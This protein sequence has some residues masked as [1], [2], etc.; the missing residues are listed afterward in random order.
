M[1]AD[2]GFERAR[3]NFGK[4]IHQFQTET[5]TL[6][7]KLERILIKLYRQNVSLLFNQTYIYI[8][9]YIYIYK[10]YK[11]PNLPMS[12]FPPDKA[13][14]NKYLPNMWCMIFIKTN[15]SAVFTVVVYTA[16]KWCMYSSLCLV[17]INWCIIRR[18]LLITELLL[19]L[20]AT[21]TTYSVT[22]GQ[23]NVCCGGLLC[24]K[25]E[26]ESHNA[27]LGSSSS[28]GKPN[29]HSFHLFLKSKQA[30][31]F[32]LVKSVWL[33]PLMYRIQTQEI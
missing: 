8:Y 25:A 30:S 14:L 3:D 20:V 16:L 31:N 1:M 32:F 2:E 7:R 28:K 4:F 33:A 19:Y 5:K 12:N 18:T 29:S 17:L 21:G 22:C 24:Q 27:L 26:N 10:E 15:S 23:R 6:I 11:L 13:I 9:I